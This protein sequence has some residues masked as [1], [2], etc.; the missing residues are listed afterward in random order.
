M[1]NDTNDAIRRATRVYTRLGLA[2][3][4]GV[5]MGLFSHLVW[6]CD[7]ARF[8]AIYKENVTENH[9]DIGVGTAYCLDRCGFRTRTPRLALIDIEENCLRHSAKRLSRY[10]PETYVRNAC[11]PIVIDGRRSIQSASAA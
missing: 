4:D 8:V 5:I 7:P 9:A 1:Q 10:S 11:E 2:L 3:Y 6:R